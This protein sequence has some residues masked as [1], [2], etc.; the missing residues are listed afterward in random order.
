MND[1]NE[2]VLENTISRPPIV[3]GASEHARLLRLAEAQHRS[4]V[5]EYLQEELGRASVVADD[6]CPP[7]VARIGSQVL[8]VDDLTGRA[9]SVT[10]VYPRDADIG[11]HRI[12]ILTPIGAA[13]IGL[14]TG[15]SIQWPDP[16]GGMSTLTV[17]AVGNDSVEKAAE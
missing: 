12:S 16:S 10:L 13:L 8:Y 3:I 14:S 6:E 17:A 1:I 7:S 5:S 11:L 2:T 15:Q 9:R 4:P